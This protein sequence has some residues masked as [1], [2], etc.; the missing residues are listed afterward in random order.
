MSARTG[1]GAQQQKWLAVETKLAKKFLHHRY[2]SV[3]VQVLAL[4]LS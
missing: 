2:F 1:F 3:A 4:N